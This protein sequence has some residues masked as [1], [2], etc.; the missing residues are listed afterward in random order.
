MLADIVAVGSNSINVLSQGTDLDDLL[1]VEVLDSGNF[2]L[3]V[4]EL[5]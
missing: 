2:S 1:R 4:I 3:G 5:D